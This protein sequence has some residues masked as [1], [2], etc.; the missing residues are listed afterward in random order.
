MV[1]VVYLCYYDLYLMRKVVIAGEDAVKTFD[2][3][4]KPSGIG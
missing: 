3:A 2:D 4:V 1:A